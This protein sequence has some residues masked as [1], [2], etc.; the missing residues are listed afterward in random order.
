MIIKPSADIRQNYSEVSRQ[1][2]ETGE[3][4][5]IT[6]SGTG[7]GVFMSLDTYE[8]QA[9]MLELKER[10]LDI[11]IARA[12]GKKDIPAS[13]FTAHFAKLAAKA[14]GQ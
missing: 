12:N 4:I 11:D 2:K 9:K 7:D 10:L 5:Y 14:K 8:R 13:E 1:A 6:V 3:P